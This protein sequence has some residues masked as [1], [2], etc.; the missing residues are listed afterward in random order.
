MSDVADSPE[1]VALRRLH[2][3]CRRGLLE[4]DLLLQHYLQR[5]AR[6]LCGEDME[7][8]NRLLECDDVTLWELLSGRAQ[9]EDAGL[10]GLVE[11]IRAA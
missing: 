10:Q 7:R 8:L 9:C 4:N 5:E 6:T 11:R 1:A 2:W 3:H